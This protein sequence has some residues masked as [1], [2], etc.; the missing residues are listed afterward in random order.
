[1]FTIAWWYMLGTYALLWAGILYGNVWAGAAIAFCFVQAGHFGMEDKNFFSLTCQVRYAT[2]GIFALGLWEP[3]AWI[4]WVPAVG[5][6]ARLTVNYCLLA[7]LVALLPWNRKE[8]L[9]RALVK[10]RI[11]SAPVRG[12][13]V[14]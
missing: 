1:M 2:A 8:P 13:V 3:M 4:L 11:F 9:T 7:R 12:S 6:A 10:A 5:I 14:R